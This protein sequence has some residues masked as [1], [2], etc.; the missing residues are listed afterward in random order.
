[1][2]ACDAGGSSLTNGYAKDVR[3]ESSNF[4][5]D[6]PIDSKRFGGRL[7]CPNKI[8]FRKSLQFSECFLA[9]SVSPIL[10]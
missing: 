6:A 1:M 3:Y 4:A 2:L 10:S 9:S 7:A 8:A 5:S